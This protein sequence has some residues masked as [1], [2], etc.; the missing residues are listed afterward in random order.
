LSPGGSPSGSTP[1]APGGGGKTLRDCMGFWERATHM[2]KAE[3]K[4]ACLRTM[5]RIANP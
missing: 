1:S 5:D 4:A 3:W 2:T